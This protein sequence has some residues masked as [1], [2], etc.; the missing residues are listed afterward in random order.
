ME[1]RQLRYFAA[2][3]AHGSFTR[4]AR[5]LHLTQPAVSRQVQN[6]EEELGT[7]LLLRT[8][9]TVALTMT[10]EQLYEEAQDLLARADQV[11]RR[12]RTQRDQS[13]VRVSYV[14]SLTAG[15]LPRAIQRFQSLAPQVRLELLDSTSREIGRR[16]A[17][18]GVDIAV[19]AQGLEGCLPEFQWMELQRLSPR[20][21][22]PRGHPLASVAAVDPTKLRGQPLHGL[23]RADFPEYAERLRVILKPFG[24]RPRLVS[25]NAD[26]IATL[27]AT[28][29]AS[30]GL[31]VLTEGVL[32]TLP[33][34]LVSR[35]FSPE[36]APLV[37]VLGVPA[38]PGN[39]HAE[40]FAR[41]LHEEAG[42][43][44]TPAP[45][46]SGCHAKARQ[47]NRV[48]GG[49]GRPKLEPTDLPPLAGGG[50]RQRL[51]MVQSHSQ[52]TRKPTSLLE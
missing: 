20:L 38:V 39:L 36:P 5:S 48:V 1:L 35:P 22:M 10:G 14:S 51:D 32:D 13:A 18:A 8:S 24:I 9:N 2:V 21:I 43:V 40:K 11:V 29:E 33:A 52:T 19:L 34:A 6:L 47:P 7:A 23:G 12:V 17:S 16:A 50:K 30:G 4:A 25:Q 46:S 42:R 37:V 28:L 26:G 49:R 27:F 31:A 45:R 15:I 41:L 3:A 44:F